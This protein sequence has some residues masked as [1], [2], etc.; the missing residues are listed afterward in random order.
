MLCCDW[1]V[2]NS[3]DWC[4]SILAVSLCCRRALKRRRSEHAHNT[5]HYRYTLGWGAVYWS[6]SA[7]VNEAI[8]IR[9]HHNNINSDSGI[10][11][12]EAGMPTIKKHNTE[13]CEKEDRRE[14]P[15]GTARNEM[16]QSQLLIISQSQQNIVLYKV[17][18]NITWWR[19]AVCSRNVAIHILSDYI[20]RQTITIIMIYIL[21]CYGRRKVSLAK[22]N[23][24]TRTLRRESSTE[25]YQI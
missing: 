3:C 17:F 1:L 25:F 15:T 7:G 4:V 13:S 5:G 16:H 12:P 11:I 19:L 24:G 2:F 10:E 20:V 23:R 8:H 9:L 18:C 6:W 22:N 14:Q 21:F